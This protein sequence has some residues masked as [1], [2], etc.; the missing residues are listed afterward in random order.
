MPARNRNSQSSLRRASISACV[1]LTLLAAA[2]LAQ[3]APTAASA[4]STKPAASQPAPRIFT[5]EDFEQDGPLFDRWSLRGA[6][7]ASRVDLG[8]ARPLDGASGRVLSITAEGNAVIESER[9][10]LTTPIVDCESFAFRID[11]S[12]ATPARPLVIFVQFH[13]RRRGGLWSRRVRIDLPGWQEIRIPLRNFRANRGAAPRWEDV[14]SL[15]FQFRTPARVLLDGLE[16]IAGNEPR[17]A[18]PTA[19]MVRELAFG[20]EAPIRELQREPF[21]VLTDALSIDED[22]LF[23]PLIAMYDGLR[24][25]FP[26]LDQPRR[27][28]ILLVFSREADYRAFWPRFAEALDSVLTPPTSDGF[29]ALGIASSSC[30]TDDCRVR[31]VF[32]HEAAH[33]LM[34]QML[35]LGSHG[36]WLTEGLA[37]RYQLRFSGQDLAPIVSSALQN[38]GERTPWIELLSGGEIRPSRYWQAALIIEWLLDE[39]QRRRQFDE[40]LE[41]V[42][43][44]SQTNVQALAQRCF[45]AT[46]PELEKQW[47]EWLKARYSD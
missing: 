21:L 24:A 8:A 29:T 18:Y 25:D 36:D 28:V 9:L 40:F 12:S 45:D 13:E 37:T 27:P 22:A 17:A 16:L 41:Q 47:L 42:R 7:Q 32:I 19:S 34:E 1:A 5:I 3:M 10:D 31:P 4:P 11:A 38:A 2:S 43:I 33:A 39:P 44:H 30:E 20:A 14:D 6:I 15:G 46:L 35:G 23:K 26:Q